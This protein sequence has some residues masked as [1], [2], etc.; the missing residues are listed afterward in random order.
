LPS[1]DAVLTHEAVQRWHELV[2][3][4]GEDDPGLER[5]RAIHYG[6][7]RIMMV[8][9][10]ALLT[11]PRYEAER[12][13]V[14]L[15]A[16]A[17]KKVVAVAHGEPAL[18]DALS[19]DP[20]EAALVAIDPGFD[21][22]DVND[23]F[24]GFISKRLGFLEV[25]GTCPGGVGWH[26]ESTRAFMETS[27]GA[28][29][30]REYALE[31]LFV[32]PELHKALVETWRDWGGSGDPTVAIVDWA[33][34]PTMPEFELIREELRAGGLETLI[35]DPRELVFD[36]GRLRCGKT[37]ID[38]VFR[39]LVMQDVLARPDEVRPLVDAARA[40]AVCMINPFAAEILAHKSVFQLLTTTHH[41]FGLSA[42]ERTAI[43]NH[44][45][46]TRAAWPSGRPRARS[47]PCRASGCSSTASGSRSS[48]STSTAGTA[49]G[50]AGRPMSAPGSAW[51][52]RRRR[53]LRHPTSGDRAPR[54][55]PGRP[56]RPPLARVLRG[57]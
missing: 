11:H 8:L 56:A 25:A 40:G 23:R 55:L 22:V 39:R 52:A 13:A 41:D 31:P 6:G 7:R 16:R 20:E 42:A 1:D 5:L 50:W 38:L 53:R 36:D 35:A 45:P 48:P 51:S 29:M 14:A 10:P 2:V 27:V 57:Q 44:V 47:T 34:V 15:V 30:A 21:N 46:W 24:D 33:D 18:L 4:L 43:D 54:A 9:R 17:L 32:L 19:I 37:A 26:D 12:L 3:E 28:A 49:P